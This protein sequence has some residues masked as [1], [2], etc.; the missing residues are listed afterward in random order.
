[1]D[2]SMT[3]VTGYRKHYNVAAII[4]GNSASCELEATPESD[5][6]F[7]FK[8]ELPNGRSKLT[9]KVKLHGG[10]CLDFPATMVYTDGDNSAMVPYYNN[11][12]FC[13]QVTGKC[14]F[15]CDCSASLCRVLNIAIISSPDHA[16]KLW[17][18]III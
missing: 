14:E 11:P 6:A 7:V 13:D 12:S 1:M 4:D 15:E 16:R 18:V 2:V 5:E 9:V 3:P 17:E 8:Y 10:D